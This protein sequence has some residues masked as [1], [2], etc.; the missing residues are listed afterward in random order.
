M[1]EFDNLNQK[2]KEKESK[3]IAEIKQLSYALKNAPKRT[4]CSKKATNR[5]KDQ[6]DL[7][8]LNKINN[9]NNE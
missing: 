7:E 5:L 6:L 4:K 2:S 8:E 1:K 9:P 3:R